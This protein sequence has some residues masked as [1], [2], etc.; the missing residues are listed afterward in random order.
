MIGIATRSGIA[1]GLNLEKVIIGLDVK[2]G[3]ARKK[4]WWSLFRL[5]S[6]LSVM[7][8]RVSCLGNASSSANPP[9]LNP[10]LDLTV[11]DMEQPINELQWTIN[12][13]EGKALP[14]VS[15]LKSL[16]P[17]HSLYCFY[18]VD[19]TLITHT[20]INEIYSLDPSRVGWSCIESRIAFYHKKLD[21]WASTIHPSFGSQFISPPREPSFQ[22]SLALNYY[23]A[24]I[25]LNRPSL[26][27]PSFEKKHDSPDSGIRFANKIAFDCL[28]ASLGAIAQLP[29]RP[30]LAWCYQVPQWWDLLHILTQSITILL[31]DISASPA[32]IRPEEI[33]FPAESVVWAGVTKGLHWLHCLGKSSESAHRAF[34]FFN[35]CVR[36]M[37]PSKT[38]DQEWLS[39]VIDSSRAS[40]GPNYSED[41]SLVINLPEDSKR[42]ISANGEDDIVFFQDLSGEQRILV[43]GA[44]AVLDTGEKLVELVSNSDFAVEDILFSLMDCHP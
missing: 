8:G 41:E 33:Q 19:L 40:C 27:G 34:L 17:T 12:L 44:L 26:K 7:T 16:E 2:S 29:D 35:T 20:I 36:R 6:L 23:S 42:H 32:L 1:L 24:H 31:L 30:D 43:P 28:Q 9:F 4:L 39:L 13:D 38:L 11:P 10:N 3:E 14:Q 37:K 22:D 25:L 21:F 5:E 15:F 18:M